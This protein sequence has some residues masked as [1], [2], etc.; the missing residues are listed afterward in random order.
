MSAAG[1]YR[2]P[3]EAA[4]ATAGENSSV[5]LSSRAVPA[6]RRASRSART[7]ASAAGMRTRAYLRQPVFNVRAISPRS[8]T[9]RYRRGTRILRCQHLS[10]RNTSP[11]MEI[12]FQAELCQVPERAKSSSTFCYKDAKEWRPHEIF[13]MLIWRDYPAERGYSQTPVSPP[14]FPDRQPAD[15]SRPDAP[16]RGGSGDP[17]SRSCRDVPARSR[18]CVPHACR[19]RAAGP[20]PRCAPDGCAPTRAAAAP[21][22]S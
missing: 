11:A 3:R 20:R 19:R 7:T 5:S 17:S 6:A 2:T 8:S 15:V 10:F 13:K 12:S 4:K 14:L 1:L 16:S 18:P 9:R 21:T 22:S